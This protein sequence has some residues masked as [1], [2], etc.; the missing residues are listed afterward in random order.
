MVG[1]KFKAGQ[2]GVMAAL[3]LLGSCR[4]EIIALNLLTYIGCWLMAISILTFCQMGQHPFFYTFL[5][6]IE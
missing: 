5:N 2:I 6:L 3:C 4:I 1:R